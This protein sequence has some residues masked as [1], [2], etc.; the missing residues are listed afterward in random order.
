MY[1]FACS[2]GLP[3]PSSAVSTWSCHSRRST[4]QG[5]VDECTQFNQ[6]QNIWT[7]TPHSLYNKNNGLF[8]EGSLCLNNPLF[9]RRFPEIFGRTTRIAGFN[10]LKRGPKL[11][12]GNIFF[13][14]PRTLVPTWTAIKYTFGTHTIVKSV[15]IFRAK[16]VVNSL[17]RRKNGVWPTSTSSPIFYS[18]TILLYFQVV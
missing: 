10:Q 5:L 18:E 6:T 3:A 12:P 11:P 13:W 17:G 2:T 7:K 14:L 4:K 9:F 1:I 15:I 16:V 8:S